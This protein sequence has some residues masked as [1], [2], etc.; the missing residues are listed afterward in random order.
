MLARASLA[1]GSGRIPWL[2]HN[3]P[4]HNAPS[5]ARAML[6]VL[7][8]CNARRATSLDCLIPLG[9]R[10]GIALE[11]YFLYPSKNAA[12]ATVQIDLTHHGHHRLDII[13]LLTIMPMQ[14][15]EM[16]RE[17]LPIVLA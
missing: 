16:G 11:P 8:E 14:D 4:F 15:L 3:W 1:L 13:L 9:P 12:G 17:L 2:I 6:C 10:A 7:L 5:T